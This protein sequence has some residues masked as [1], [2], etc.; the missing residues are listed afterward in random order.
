MFF[1]SADVQQTG[2]ELTVHGEA[3]SGA[4]GAVWVRVELAGVAGL[5]LRPDRP[6]GQLGVAQAAA[7]ANPTRE[8]LGYALV[9]ALGV[10][11]HGGG[12]ALL[13]RLPPQHLV[14]PLGEAVPAG[15]GGRLPAHGRLVALQAHFA[16]DKRHAAVID[17]LHQENEDDTLCHYVTVCL[18]CVGYF[19]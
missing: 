4:P 15:Q 8:L 14:H 18:L 16:W 10:G 1:K 6:D 17:I 19:C 2:E 12:V 3:G 7:Q 13:G 9:A 5:V 11:G